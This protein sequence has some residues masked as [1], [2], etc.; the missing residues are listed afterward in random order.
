M[1]GRSSRVDGVTEWYQTRTGR[2]W[3]AYRQG[4]S[5]RARCGKEIVV[6][7]EVHL[8]RPAG[9]SC[10]NCLRALQRDVERDNRG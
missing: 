1:A 9:K 4:D 3:H 7:A 8:E 5:Q 2:S 6:T 10:E